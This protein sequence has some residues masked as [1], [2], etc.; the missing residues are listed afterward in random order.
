MIGEYSM[1]CR[2]KKLAAEFHAWHQMFENV[3]LLKSHFI[4]IVKI[5]P[6][7]DLDIKAKF[8]SVRRRDLFR[9]QIR[10]DHF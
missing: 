3:F 6:I 4:A 9:V 2:Q 1:E 5:N 10:L 7:P 8:V